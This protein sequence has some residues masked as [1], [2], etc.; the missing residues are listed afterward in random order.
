MIIVAGH[1]TIDP[2]HRDTALAAIAT[3][4]AATRAEP[5]NLEYRFSPDLDEP[6]RLN[7]IERW[8]DE[9][10]MAEHMATPHLAEFMGAIVPCLGGSAEVIRYDV[11]GSAPLF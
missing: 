2:D 8:S 10:A 1:L 5:G 3:C 11:S 9:Q 7:L 6:D 4:V